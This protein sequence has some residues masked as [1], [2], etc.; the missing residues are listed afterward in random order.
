M[1]KYKIEKLKVFAVIDTN[2]IVSIANGPDEDSPIKQI[3][4]L[5]ETGNI[6]PLF[7]ER[8][9]SEYYAVLNYSRLSFLPEMVEHQMKLILSRGIFVKDVKE[10]DVLF[11]DKT[12]IPFYEVTLSTSELDSELVTGNTKHYPEGS[13]VSPRTLLNH[14]HYIEEMFGNL[15]ES[16]GKYEEN[17]QKKIVDL[18]ESGRY[19]L[20]SILPEE[21]IK[22]IEEHRLGVREYIDLDD[23]IMD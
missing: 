5:I 11:I 14:M 18:I 9:L 7:D 12:D 10:L 2:V 19:C 3:G 1:H 16:K 4:E 17:V 8:I 22:K 21:F 6:I 23:Y 13:C 20:G 15:M